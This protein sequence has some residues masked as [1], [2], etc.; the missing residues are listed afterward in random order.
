MV[1]K[2]KNTIS[3]RVTIEHH[4][5]KIEYPDKNLPKRLN[6]DELE[7]ADLKFLFHTDHVDLSTARENQ[8]VFFSRFLSTFLRYFWSMIPAGKSVATFS[9][10]FRKR[11]F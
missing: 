3:V 4:I 5:L 11:D 2:V 9:L 1:I 8:N 7:P 10:N 6:T